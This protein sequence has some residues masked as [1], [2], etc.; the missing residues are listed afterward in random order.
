[1]SLLSNISM[2]IIP[3]NIW[4]SVIISA[5]SQTLYLI[6]TVIQSYSQYLHSSSYL[7]P[8]AYSPDLSP[9]LGDYTDDVIIL[10]ESNAHHCA[11]HSNIADD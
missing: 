10:G 2:Q 6:C 5:Y 4:G 8:V 9:V 3:T 7:S 11:F 1:M